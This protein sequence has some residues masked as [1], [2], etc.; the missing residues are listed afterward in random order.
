[1]S[2]ISIIPDTLLSDIMLESAS[3]DM[4]FALGLAAV[5]ARWRAV[6]LGSRRL[7][8][9][10]RLES[11]WDIRALPIFLARSE[12]VPLHIKLHFARNDYSLTTAS[13]AE[14][15]AQA[16]GLLAHCTGRIRCLNVR[17]GAEPLF[18]ALLA[19]GLHFDILD[20]LVHDYN[21]SFGD[22]APVSLS[23]P[24]LTRLRLDR[25]MSDRWDQ[26]LGH[27]L[28]ALS[29][30]R[31][32]E[33]FIDTQL[34]R[35]IFLGC[36]KLQELLLHEDTILSEHSDVQMPAFTSRI[37]APALRRL[38]I[39]SHIDNVATILAGLSEVF[40]PSIF[41][42]FYDGDFDGHPLMYDLMRGISPLVS[43]TVEDDQSALLV[44]AVG[45]ERRILLE[46]YDSPYWDYSALWA[47]LVRHH[48]A[49]SS[50]HTIR[51]AAGHILELT[52]AICEWPPSSEPP[53]K[54]QIR[55]DDTFRQA[56]HDGDFDGD[57]Y[58]AHVFLSCPPQSRFC[59]E[60]LWSDHSAVRHMLR[61]I[62][63]TQ[64]VVVCFNEVQEAG[65]T[66]EGSKFQLLRVLQ[67]EM[68]DQGQ[69][70]QWTLCTDCVSSTH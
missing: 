4:A 50:V 33:P 48:N 52:P 40:I 35:A 22:F 30:S 55:L 63:S 39:Q 24:Q 18:D 2:P 12:P 67:M 1:M 19:T 45:I 31:Q 14:E 25:V 10:F 16:V 66:D 36:P 51:C 61:L 11:S 60:G 70:C 9:R 62:K 57:G 64:D 59:L 5:S 42:S 21:I 47:Y 13:T 56:I 27:H 15:R 26:I 49:Q 54:F 32:Y 7:W 58:Y 38:D 69:H 46:N 68:F 53:F 29:I 8:A 37:P 23:A 43:I 41:I 28:T 17:R 65:G 34:L 6:A 44:D 20:E 3:F